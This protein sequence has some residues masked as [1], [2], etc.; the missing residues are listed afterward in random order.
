M[1]QKDKLDL[2]VK[3]YFATS[4]TAKKQIYKTMKQL[5][6]VIIRELSHRIDSSLCSLWEEEK[7]IHL[8]QHNSMT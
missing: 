2:A 8:K 7:R 1:K 6:Y 4:H 5:N 3:L